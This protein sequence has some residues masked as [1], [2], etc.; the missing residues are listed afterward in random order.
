MLAQSWDANARCIK[1][2]IDRQTLA[3][4]EGGFW[5]A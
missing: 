5:A 4:D 3:V 2:T 1:A